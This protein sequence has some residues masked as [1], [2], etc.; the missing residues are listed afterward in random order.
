MISWIQKYFQKHFKFVFLMVLIA[1][2]LPMVVIYSSS[3]GGHAENIKVLERPFF[4]VNL[5][6]PQGTQKVTDIEAEIANAQSIMKL[7]KDRQQQ[8]ES[9]LSGMLDAISGV[10]TEQVGAEILAM[11]TRLQATLQTTALLAKMSLVNY[12]TP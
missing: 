10:A 9:T 3:G 6:S 4:G 12:L 1:I 5:A 11:Q 8:T 7:T 2:G